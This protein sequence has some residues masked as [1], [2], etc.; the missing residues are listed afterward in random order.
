M[1]EVDERVNGGMFSNARPVFEDMVT[2]ADGST[3]FTRATDRLDVSE[4]RREVR[5]LEFVP[6]SR[7]SSDP[8]A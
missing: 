5:R 2:F 1:N 7:G 4:M 3:V 8:P 6:D